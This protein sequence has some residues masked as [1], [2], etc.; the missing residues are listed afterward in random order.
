MKSFK[1][2]L[3]EHLKPVDFKTI[4]KVL[5]SNGIPAD[6]ISRIT[7]SFFDSECLSID[8]NDVLK[9]AYFSENETENKKNI[10]KLNNSL[11]KYKWSVNYVNSEENKIWIRQQNI[12][13]ISTTTTVDPSDW[14]NAA[15]DDTDLKPTTYDIRKYGFL[16]VTDIPPDIITRTG[17]R[18]KESKTFDK[19]DEK[20]IYLFSLAPGFINRRPNITDNVTPETIASL[21]CDTTYPLAHY[22]VNFA[23]AR[24]TS[25]TEDPN[26]HKYVYF[27]KQLPKPAKIYKDDMFHRDTNLRNAVFI[28]DYNIPP[29]YIQFVCT[30]D[31]LK[32]AVANMCVDDG[33]PTASN[34]DML[35]PNS[36]YKRIIDNKLYDKLAETYK[37]NSMFK[38]IIHLARHILL[39]SYEYNLSV[40]E[41]L[42][43]CSTDAII[44]RNLYYELFECETAMEYLHDETNQKK[45]VVYRAFYSRYADMIVAVVLNALNHKG[46]QGAAQFDDFVI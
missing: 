37:N 13:D 43:L 33:F 38:R 44:V 25:E 4:T 46:I 36:K 15:E 22:I 32:D 11:L 6:K 27:I 17:L 19:H 14:I 28:K 34:I 40:D 10:E 12:R 8:C 9:D 35:L 5:T 3:T 31:E 20:R 1:E 26:T 41:I 30:I 42:K 21:R 16:H 29:S 18:A 24:V 23:E 39:N 45:E 2:F 7:R